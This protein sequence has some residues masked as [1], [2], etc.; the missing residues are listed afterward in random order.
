MI[1]Y[2]QRVEEKIRSAETKKPLPTWRR[3]ERIACGAPIWAGIIRILEEISEQL[4]DRTDKGSRRF[5][6]RSRAY[7]HFLIQLEDYGR[8]LS[9]AARARVRRLGDAGASKM[10]V[11]DAVI[12]RLLDRKTG[13]LN[14]R[15]KRSLQVLALGVSWHILAT[16]STALLLVL[17]IAV[18]GALILKLLVAGALIAFFVYSFALINALTVRQYFAFP[19]FVVFAKAMERSIAPPLKAVS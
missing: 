10:L 5:H 1:G 13:E 9:G 3:I 4:I 2:K 11:R 7:C 19:S 8:M 16:I 6:R 14:L 15:K 17:V 12:G 18:P